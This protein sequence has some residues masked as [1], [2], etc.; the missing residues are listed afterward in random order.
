MVSL[1]VETVENYLGGWR[2]GEHINREIE[3]EREI[4]T[5]E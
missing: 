4:K 1:S 5:T 3:E 2:T